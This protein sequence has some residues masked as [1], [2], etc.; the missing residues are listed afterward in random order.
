MLTFD[1]NCR[2]KFLNLESRPKRLLQTQDSALTFS[3]RLEI[4]LDQIRLLAQKLHM[5]VRSL[6]EETQCSRGLLEGFGKF[7]LFLISPGAFEIAELAMD[8][9]DQRLKL[10]IKPVQVLGKPPEF[11][12]IYMRLRHD[13]DLSSDYRF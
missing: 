1:T 10:V 7:L 9:A 5:L 3:A 13:H 6:K 8:V 12:R 4:F 11:T 2:L